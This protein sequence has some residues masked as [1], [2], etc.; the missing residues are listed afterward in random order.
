MEDFQ[1]H[2]CAAIDEISVPNNDDQVVFR[3]SDRMVP[4]LLP[5]A[6]DLA[7]SFDSA[8]LDLSDGAVL[9]TG[10]LGGVGIRVACW[11][12][13]QG[14]QHLVLSSRSGTPTDSVAE[15][16]QRMRSQGARVDVIAADTSTP[17]GVK[18]CLEAT[19]GAPS[20]SYTHLTLPTIC[21]V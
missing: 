1:N 18:C 20:V 13:E 19:G 4:R 7:G 10:G 14:A 11:L 21:S 2:G 16:I 12:A 8:T 5:F 3:G 15:L 6:S 9:I 17:D